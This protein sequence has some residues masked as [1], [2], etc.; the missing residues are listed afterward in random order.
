LEST[1]TVWKLQV[2]PVRMFRAGFYAAPTGGGVF[3][4]GAGTVT[5]QV[6]KVHLNTAPTDPDVTGTFT[7]V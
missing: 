6:A 2:G 1:T 5:L 4:A 3:Q 7:F